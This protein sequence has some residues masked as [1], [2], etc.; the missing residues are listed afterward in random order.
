MCALADHIFTSRSLRSHVRRRLDVIKG[1]Q[2]CNESGLTSLNLHNNKFIHFSWRRRKKKR[3]RK[4]EIYLPVVHLQVEA[5][6]AFSLRHGKILSCGV[7]LELERMEG[8]HAVTMC[9]VFLNVWMQNS[10]G[11]LVRIGQR[12]ENPFEPPTQRALQVP[13]PR[14]Q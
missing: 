14:H 8:R 6:W 7:N 4:K 1:A 12:T 11:E 9:L 10:W 3:E 13:V 5:E 2:R